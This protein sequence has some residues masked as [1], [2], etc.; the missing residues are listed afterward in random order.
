VAHLRGLDEGAWERM[1]ESIGSH[2]P[3]DIA[4][5]IAALRREG[6]L[7]EQADGAIRLPSQPP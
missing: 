1:P 3:A 7:E 2:G 4:V 6:L 5:A